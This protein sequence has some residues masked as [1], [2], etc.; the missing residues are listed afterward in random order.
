MRGMLRPLPALERALS[1]ARGVEEILQCGHGSRR[2]FFLR[3]MPEI[4]EYNETAAG[5]VAVK[6]FGVFGRNQAVAAAP[7]DERRQL[8]RGNPAGLAPKVG[9]S[10]AL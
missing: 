9:L 5:D 3:H 7:N 1:L 6:M 8:Q 2:V 10:E 4:A